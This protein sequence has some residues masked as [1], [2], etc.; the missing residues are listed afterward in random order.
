MFKR[1]IELEDRIMDA[2]DSNFS[3][4]IIVFTV[5]SMALAVFGGAVLTVCLSI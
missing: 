5:M 4:A 2:A 1:L 3:V